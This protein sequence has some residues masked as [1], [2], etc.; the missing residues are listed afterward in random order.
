[1]MEPLQTG[2]ISNIVKKIFGT[3]LLLIFSILII[4][5]FKTGAYKS[6]KVMKTKP[7][8]LHMFY[9]KNTGPYHQIVEKI[10]KVEKIFKNLQFPCKKTFGHFLSDSKIIDHNKLLSHVGCAFY[11]TET[12]KLP[13]LIK[14]VEEKFF[15][16]KSKEKICY[17]G[18][19]KGSP[20]LS[21]I[22]IY[23]K[24]Y[25]LAQQDKVK[26]KPD[27][28]EVYTVDGDKVTTDVYLCEE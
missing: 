26:L 11:K 27:S 14:G 23:P 20:S 12:K 18:T 13:Q 22:K 25:K 3:F 15:G 8:Q 10:Q 28:L 16:L 17:K 21:G 7:P 1:M 19:F 2:E 5:F 9:I 6:V 4:L 24:L